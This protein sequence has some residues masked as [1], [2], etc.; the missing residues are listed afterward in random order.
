[1]WGWGWVGVWCV[2]IYMCVMV[3]DQLWILFLT[4]VPQ[5]FEIRSLDGLE[6][7]GRLYSFCLCLLQVEIQVCTLV[8]ILL[9]VGS[10]ALAW[11][12]RFIYMAGPF[13]E[14]SPNPASLILF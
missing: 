10:R 5:F 11:V 7:S 3:R 8:S 6:L 14:A 9:P 13:P 4:P 1:M 2:Y 12:L